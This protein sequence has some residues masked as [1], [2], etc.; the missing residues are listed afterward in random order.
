MDLD[1]F[2]FLEKEYKEISLYLDEI[3]NR[4]EKIVSHTNK[5]N[6]LFNELNTMYNEYLSQKKNIT[7]F[8]N[9]CRQNINSL[10]CHNYVKDL[11]DLTPERSEIVEYCI[12]CGHTKS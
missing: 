7:H 12:L 4:Y 2:L 5:N 3:I 9:N 6:E 11:I 10:C 8:L 1:Y